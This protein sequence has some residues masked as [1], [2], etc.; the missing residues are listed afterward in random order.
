MSKKH[1]QQMIYDH[2]NEST[3]HKKLDK[4]VNKGMLKL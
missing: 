4:D 1:Y 3:T 2:V